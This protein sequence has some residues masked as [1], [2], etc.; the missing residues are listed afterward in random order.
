MMAKDA[1]GIANQ[2]ASYF[3]GFIICIVV[4]VLGL[5]VGIV[6]DLFIELVPVLLVMCPVG[7]FLGWWVLQ[8]IPAS[9]EA[10]LQQTLGRAG[11]F[12]FAGVLLRFFREMCS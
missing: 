7:G 1:K 12:I 8:D 6:I 2:I 3:I 9:T 5:T 11:S 10:L 4:I